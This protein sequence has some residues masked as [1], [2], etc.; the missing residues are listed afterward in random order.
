M[1]TVTCVN[2]SARPA[3]NKKYKLCNEC[4]YK[5]LHD[6][7]SRV[8]ILLTKQKPKKRYTLRQQTKK[9]PIISKQLSAL[10]SEIELEKIQNGEYYC[11]GCGISKSGLDKSH[12]LSVGRYK[13]LELVKKNIQLLCRD[14]HNI[15][16]HGSIQEKKRLLC[17]EENLEII[18]SLNQLAYQKF[19]NED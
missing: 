14:C 13:N 8:E 1:S 7:K 12:I 11:K 15:W 3:V 18:R 9:Q 2:H 10:K 4:N 19:L 5:R 6:G 17:Y 16:E